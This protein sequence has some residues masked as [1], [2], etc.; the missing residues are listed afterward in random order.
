MNESIWNT[1][2]FLTFALFAIPACITDMREY[3]IP[4]IYVIA[5]AVSLAVL[6]IFAYKTCVSKIFLDMIPGT[7]VFLTIRAITG[8]KLGMGD[9]KFAAFMGVFT[10]FPCWFLA[11]L[12]ASLLGIAFTI[13]AIAMGK[14]S[15]D[16]RIPFAPFLT[17]GSMGAYIILPLLQNFTG[18]F[19]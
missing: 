2:Y 3:K 1:F 18:R 5:G 10:G 9:V 14:L 15:R 19:P 16:S 7:A 12:L 17:A 13:A 8:N 4:D 11:T 6:R